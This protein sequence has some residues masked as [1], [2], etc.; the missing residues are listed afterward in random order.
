MLSA[1]VI[2]VNICIKK[3]TCSTFCFII[4]FICCSNFDIL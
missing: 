1:Q 3:C 2:F 4:S